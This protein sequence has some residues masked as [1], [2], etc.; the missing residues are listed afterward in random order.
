MTVGEMPWHRH[1]QYVDFVNT[2]YSADAGVGVWAPPLCNYH[3]DAAGNDYG[4]H[5]NTMNGVGGSGFHQQVPV[6]YSTYFYRR[7]S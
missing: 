2:G 5:G 7:I 1:A 3:H 4:N 6:H